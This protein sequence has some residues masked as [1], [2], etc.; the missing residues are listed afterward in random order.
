MRASRPVTLNLA[1]TRLS[2]ELS[3]SVKLT[4]QQPAQMHDRAA[5]D[6]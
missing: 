4:D 5:L 6:L 2:K 3:G 1:T